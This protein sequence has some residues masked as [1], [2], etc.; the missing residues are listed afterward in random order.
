VSNLAY[1]TRAADMLHPLFLVVSFCFGA[2]LGSF[3]NVCIGRWPEGLSVIKPASRCPQCGNGIAWF[4]NIP[5]LS[6]LVLRARCRHCSLPISWRYPV[7]ELLTAGLFLAV[8]LRFG[9]TIATPI[10]MFLSFA[11]VVC[12]FQDFADWTIPDE[13]TLPGIP[14]SLVVSVVGMVYGEATGLRVVSVFDALAG[15]AL[16]AAI[17]FL[18]DRVT[19][20]LLKKP[21][22]GFGDVKLLAMIGGFIGWQ[23]V[24]GSFMLACLLGSVIG[25]AVILYFKAFPP[26]E[27]DADAVLDAPVPEGSEDDGIH[28]EGHYLPF[29]PYLAIAGLLWV[30]FGPEIL[31]WYLALMTLPG[32]SPVQSL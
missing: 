13:I 11:L 18:I 23:G 20:L 29:G 28:L 15:V 31:A 21:G 25:L 1:L 30:F 9:F 14:A 5:V 12:T 22:M 10:Y 4:D 2:V 32:Y 6:W 3:A 26:K 7:V 16:G 17:P 24:L 27:R 8:Y 19:V